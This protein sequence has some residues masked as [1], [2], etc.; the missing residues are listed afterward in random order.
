[1]QFKTNNLLLYIRLWRPFFHIFLI[2]ISFW[3]VYNIRQKTD[4]IP[5][6]HIRIPYLDATDTLIFV[7]FALVFFVTIGFS[8]GLYRLSG[9]IHWYYKKLFQTWLLWVVFIS[10][11]AFYWLDF[12]FK[13]WISR[14]VILWGSILSLVMV[15]IFDVFWNNLNFRLERK[16]PYKVL[17]IYKNKDLYYKFL[18]NFKDYDIYQIDGLSIEN[19]DSNLINNYDIVFTIGEFD[20][21]FLQM[22]SDKARLADK[23]IYYLHNSFFVEDLVYKPN[24]IGPILAFEYYHSPLDG[25][26]R[27]V[28]RIFDIV[29]SL[30]FILFFW[31]LYVLIAILIYIKDWRP[32]IYKSLRVWKWWK[33]FWMYKFRT[34]IKDADKLKS[35]LQSQNE[36]TGPLFKLSNDPRITSWGRFLRRTSLDEIPQFFN[37]LKWQMSVVG[38]RPHLPEEVEKYKGWQKRLLSVKPWITGYAQVFGRDSLSFDEEAQL[39]LFYIQ[40]WSLFLDIYVIITTLRVLFKWK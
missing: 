7:I 38:P 34:M 31:W 32:I 3:I 16:S 30:V 36:R 2:W 10:F 33:T 15:L 39:D 37:V 25:R 6:V 23:K 27:V 29:F 17:A 28:K 24:R 22:L 5:F 11:V 40:N 4:L 26:W 12:L 35:Q 18:E 21:D 13:N 1:M 8:L 20:Q 9:P 19:F 14:L